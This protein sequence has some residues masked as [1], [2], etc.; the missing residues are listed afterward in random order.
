MAERPYP[1]YFIYK[2]KAGEYRWRYNAVN[3]RIIADSG[4]GYNTKADC[5][6]GIEIMQTSG[7]SPIWKAGDVE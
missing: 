4:E 3:G 1:S 6:R 5:K 7:Q 2:D